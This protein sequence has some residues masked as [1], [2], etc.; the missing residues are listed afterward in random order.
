MALNRLSNANG[1]SLATVTSIGSE[2][3]PADFPA[4]VFSS[5]DGLEGEQPSR[6]DRVLLT[7]IAWMLVGNVLYGFSQW[8]Q[9]VALAKIGTI[10]MVGNFALA[11]AVCLPVLM[12]SSL[13]LRSLQV[14]DYKRSHRF[15]EYMGLRLVM[16][17]LSLA[18]IVAFGLAA[19]YSSAVI[20]STVLIGAAKAVEY[21]SDILYGSLQQQ[22]NMSGIAISMSL[23]AI[24]SVG[25]LSLGVYLTN[26]LAWGAVCLLASSSFVLLAY[27]IPKSL[28]VG[29]VPFKLLKTECSLYFKEVMAKRGL[30]RLWKLGMAGLPLGFVL[31]MVS[32]NLNIPRYFIQQ[33]LGTPELAIFSAIATLLSAGS[34]VTNAMGQ[35]AAPRLAKCFAN[36]DQRGFNV[37]LAALVVASLGLG[38]LGFLGAVLFGKQAMAFI[39]RPE[40]S[41]HHDVLLWLMGASGFFYLGSTLGYAV[42]AVRCFKPQLP[43]FAGAAVTT[44]IGCI[45]LVPSQGLR[46]VAMAILISAVIQCAG[47]ARLLW[48]ARKTAR[49]ETA[50][51]PNFQVMA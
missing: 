23:R 30:E 36:R 42:T 50:A 11:L 3:E 48:N 51:S 40:Y 17:C 28:A 35:A 13:S 12:F 10:E 16:L 18:F 31:M 1:S 25:A 32:L 22:E 19:G 6:P 47:S 7:N 9:L 37:L 46:G 26:S 43:L 2:A 38:G 39:Y 41:T 24:L 27:D 5:H 14:T 49:N 34:V 21:V 29:K 33:R 44:A 45:A 15:L 20:L 4:K 8:G